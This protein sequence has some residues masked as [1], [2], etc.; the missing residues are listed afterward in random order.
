MGNQKKVKRTKK[1]V[2]AKRDKEA[3]LHKQAESIARKHLDALNG[4]IA[5][6]DAHKEEYV[7]NPEKDFTRKRKIMFDDVIKFQLGIKSNSLRRESQAYF[8]EL[9]N[10]DIYASAYVQQRNKLKDNTFYVLM[11][12]FNEFCLQERGLKT[13]EGYR[14]MPVD[15]TVVNIPYNYESDTFVR[16][17][18]KN[19]AK[20]TQMEKLQETMLKDF[21]LLPGSPDR[22]SQ[23]LKN[24]TEKAEKKSKRKNT[25]PKEQRESGFNQFHITTMYDAPNKLFLDA[26]IQPEGKNNE[27]RACIN[28]IKRN[29]FK[30]K[31]ILVADRG[32]G[33]RNL[34][35]YCELKENLDYAIRVKNDFTKR[36][37]ALPLEAFDIDITDE[38]RT[39]QF[40]EDREAYQSGRAC[41]LTAP[42]KDGKNRQPVTWDFESPCVITYRVVRFE[43]AKGNYETIV[44][45]LDREQF[46]AEKLKEL[47]H[48]RWEVETAYRWYKYAVGGSCF[49]SKNELYIQQEIYSRIIMFNFCFTIASQVEIE[50][51]KEWKHKYVVNYTAAITICIDYFRK[52][53]AGNEEE[54]I[55]L[56]LKNKL[57]IREGRQNE[58]NLIAKRYESCNYRKTAA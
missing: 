31:T 46:P 50:Q 19:D 5:D 3:F 51:K 24:R 29:T 26:E 55:W 36:I 40:K 52:Q 35:H 23:K 49:H 18:Q 54:I 47:Y 42:S 9:R 37:K 27:V 30:Q 7:K 25:V 13:W 39:G 38:I 11:N 17:R 8:G 45:S 44:T 43:I 56:I 21:N 14:I 28:M 6:M 32:F 15:G 33:S 20:M 10:I 34:F 48:M 58:R 53:D 22:K 41:R 1:T 2:S 16:G 57:P 12:R 4:I